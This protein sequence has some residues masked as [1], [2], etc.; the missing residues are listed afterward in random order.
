MVGNA[1]CCG[2]LQTCCHH[3]D[4]QNYIIEGD[5]EI[6]YS[7]WLSLCASGLSLAVRICSQDNVDPST[8]KGMESEN[9]YI[10]RG[11][12]KAITGMDVAAKVIKLKLRFEVAREFGDP[13]ALVV[14]NKDKHKFF[15]K[16]ASLRY[17][18]RSDVPKDQRFRFY[19]GSWVYPITKTRIK[20]IFFS[21]QLYLPKCT[22]KGLEKL[23]QKELEKLRRG[24][25][26]ERKTWD[27]IY[28]YDCYND[29]GDPDNGRHH[30]RPVL[31]GSTQFPYPRRL[32]T[33]RPPCREDHLA[34]SRPVS[35]SQIYVPP[36][37]RLSPEKQEELKNNFVD[38]LVRFLAQKS[39]REPLFNQECPDLVA[40][41]AHFF[42][43]KAAISIEDFKFIESIVDFLGKKPKPSPNQDPSDDDPFGIE[44][45][46]ADKEVKGLEESIKQKLQKLVPDEIFKDVATAA[47]K[48][49]PV[50]S[51][52]PSIITEDKNEW[53][54]NREFG[55]QMLAGTNPVRIR[56]ITDDDLKLVRGELG[57]LIEEARNENKVLFILEHHD[58]LKPFLRTINGKGVCAY[59]TRTI[60]ELNSM[61]GRIYP[62]AIELSLPDDFNG[63]RHSRVFS[64]YDLDDDD[65]YLWQVARIHV[66][67]NDA[68]YH[69]LI[70][71]WLH[72][73]AVVEPFIIATRRQLSVMHPIH[74]LLHPHFK[75][76][77][78]VNALGRA[79][80]LNA[81]GILET[82]LFTGEFSMRLSS[83]LYK[84][85]RFDDQALPADLLKRGMATPKPK[86]DES[87]STEPKEI[88][89]M[90][91][92]TDD[93]VESVER[94]KNPTNKDKDAVEPDKMPETD[95]PP[96]QQQQPTFD[97][98]VDLVIEDYPYAKDGLEIWVAIET[99]VKGYSKVFYKEDSDVIK[100]TEI[101]AWWSEIRSV[102]HG[103]Q[104]QGWYDINTV[105]N[106]VKALTTLIWITSGLHAAVNFGQYGYYGWPPN[107]PMLLRKFV[108][109]ENTPE[110]EELK[111]D[112]DKFV[113]RMLPEKFQMAFVTAVMDVLSRHTSDEV[114]LG[115]PSPEKEWETGEI[116]KMFADFRE[117]LKQ[118][119]GNIRERNKKYELFN[120]RGFVKIPY[121]LLYPYASKT[122]AASS[123][124]E[125]EKMDI[126]ERGIPNSISI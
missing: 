74:R 78:H 119:E 92:K 20:R 7:P 67:S 103:D 107:R 79:I 115:Q 17:T 77:L 22:P 114:Y 71:H 45:L 122:I 124:G 125:P 98:G 3:H 27:R 61:R 62:I 85:W 49:R 13:G 53:Y 11:E 19:C 57:K 120:R 6:D 52:P 39:T 70:S 46:F 58:Y 5:F 80:F 101:Q 110:M 24:S 42:V 117:K 100:D 1:G 126:N 2:L 84:Q 65:Y 75:D 14:E 89:E 32:R 64:W 69:Q 102:G 50:S 87:K 48:R 90:P 91:A 56:R 72:T 44:D 93:V 108:P 47:A 59:A 12:T 21:N 109:V 113:A 38:A 88:Q 106:L 16:S 68:A 37:E 33:G 43:P 18:N 121:M 8:G 26:D 94:D 76:T 31:G 111:A 54:Y 95:K 40:K 73:H 51:Q 23:R 123:K 36:D 28:E 29:L 55:R 86:K 4:P 66:A 104:R 63:E 82:T 41:I 25:K 15:L 97:A 99:W 9:A 96:P 34:E 30:A 105:E 10:T 60:L 35:C 118:I 112:P 81:G 116:G 83:L